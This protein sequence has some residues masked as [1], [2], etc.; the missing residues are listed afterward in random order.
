VLL[1]QRWAFL[2]CTPFLSEAQSTFEGRLQIP[3]CQIVWKE[4]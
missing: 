3:A 2:P 1:L 4:A